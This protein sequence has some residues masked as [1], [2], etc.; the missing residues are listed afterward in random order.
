MHHVITWP[1]Q[2]NKHSWS[3]TRRVWFEE[4]LCNENSDLTGARRFI[5]ICTHDRISRLLTVG[6]TSYLNECVAS[7][8]HTHMFI[9]V[10]CILYIA[11]EYYIMWRNQIFALQLST[12]EQWL[13][14]QQ[15]RRWMTSQSALTLEIKENNLLTFNNKPHM[16]L[17]LVSN[18]Q[19]QR[20]G[21]TWGLDLQKPQDT[22]RWREGDLLYPYIS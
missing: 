8:K 11:C 4:K 15:W 3:F 14:P 16:I 13:N 22:H 2:D 21:H 20:P 18:L 9:L 12:S 10:V 7:H 17:F 1:Q 6:V 5:G 19:T